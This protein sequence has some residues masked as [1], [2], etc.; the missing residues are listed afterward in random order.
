MTVG[1]VGGR[2]G[3]QAGEQRGFLRGVGSRGDQEFVPAWEVPSGFG[4]GEMKR[5]AQ[6]RHAKA[7]MG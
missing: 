4:Y 1:D 5:L 6:G 3:T 2:A 7:G